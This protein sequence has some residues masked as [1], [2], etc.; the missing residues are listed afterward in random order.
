[1]PFLR[2]ADDAFDLIVKAV[3]GSARTRVA[4]P[5]GDG[6]KVRVAAPAR[7]G[8]ANEAIIARLS[9]TLGLPERNIEL[10]RG[11]GAPR[12]AF[13][14]RGIPPEIARRLLTVRRSL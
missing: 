14:V 9:A 6:L 13:H 12:K 4:G 10:R 5:L 11:A 8:R 7:D 2:P 1:M 3:P